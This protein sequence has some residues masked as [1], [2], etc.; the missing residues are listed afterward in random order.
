MKSK[1]IVVLIILFAFI[2]WRGTKSILAKMGMDCEWH[3][4]Y[5]FCKAPVKNT[6]MPNFMEIFKAGIKFK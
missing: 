5:A 6:Q 3:V 4:F 2:Y 1:I